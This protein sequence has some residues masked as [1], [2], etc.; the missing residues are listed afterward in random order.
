MSS[1]ASRRGLSWRFVFLTAAALATLPALAASP[2]GCARQ[3]PCQFNSDCPIG[4]CQDGACKKSCVDSERDC[5]SG[6]T[7]DQNAQCVPGASGSGG[8]GGGA[9]GTTGSTSVA[10]S[11]TVGS[12]TTVGTTSASTTGTGLTTSSS[13]SSSSTTS[14][15]TGSLHELD[16]CASDAQCAS[17]LICR[18]LVSGGA[19]RCTRTCPSPAGCMTGTRCELV[20]GL[21]YCAGDDV[22]GGCSAASD[23]NFGCLGGLYCTAACTTGS[24]CPNG[25]GCM[26]GFGSPLQS[27]CIRAEAPC[28]NQTQNGTAACVGLG[29]CDDE[30][31]ELVVGGCTSACTSAFDCPQ[32]AAGLPPWTCE[33][34]LCRR[35]SDVVG[36]LPGGA[37]PAQ[38]ACDGS[39]DEANVCNDNQHI[40]F[41]AFDIP[42]PPQVTCGAP[43]TTAGIPTDSCLDSCRY[44]GGCAFGFAC[45]A[46]GGVGT[47]RIGLCLPTGFGEVGAPCAHDDECAFG[48]CTTAGTCSRDC[49]ADGVC[50]GNT[51]CVSVGGPA[52]EGLAFRR[53]Q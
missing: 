16:L 53:C 44:E 27:V 17:P 18:A 51:A 40:D 13:S 15:G 11:T 47:A 45:V 19:Q 5:P 4:Y 8:T 3:T 37:T 43:T 42:T 28:S 31:P 21:Q 24:D 46:L 36:P 25:Y 10:A 33:G 14:G 12:T 20:G 23:C 49:T 9:G 22:G 7:C 35:P 39:G 38:Y 2:L 32:R 48:Y 30:S 52:V 29:Y 34:G 50:P 41:D 6:Y 26:A 1:R